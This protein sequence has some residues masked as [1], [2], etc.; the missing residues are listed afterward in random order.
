[1]IRYIA[2]PA[3]IVG[4]ISWLFLLPV[5]D[6]QAATNEPDPR[7]KKVGGRCEGCDAIYECP[8]PFRLLDAIDTLPDFQSAGPRLL[9]TGRVVHADRQT[10]APGIVIYIYHTNQQGVYPNAGKRKGEGSRHGDLRGWVRTDNQGHYSFYTLK[11]APYPESNNPAHIHITIKEPGL[12]AYWI[13]EFLFTGDPY[14][15]GPDS[16]ERTLPKG[17]NGIITLSGKDGMLLAKRDIVL[18]ENIDGYPNK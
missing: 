1:M 4:F 7:D 6:Q 13:D 14:L 11:P 10:P 17:G 2:I 12:T 15:P 9:V 8:L 5:R 16:R 18:G 3:A